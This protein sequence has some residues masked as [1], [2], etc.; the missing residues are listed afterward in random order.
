MDCRR[1]HSFVSD[2]I[3]VAFFETCEHST[4]L[5]EG[6]N[7]RSRRVRVIY[8][9]SFFLSPATILALFKKRR[10]DRAN[11]IHKKGT[12]EMHIACFATRL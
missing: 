11:G 9:R 5:Y 12:V 4:F 1:H 6:G 7:C 3:H 10:S 8:A 2:V